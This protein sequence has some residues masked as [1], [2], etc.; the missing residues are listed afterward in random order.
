MFLQYKHLQER[1]SYENRL[2]LLMRRLI[3]F[4]SSRN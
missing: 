1:N 4:I 3:K 2:N